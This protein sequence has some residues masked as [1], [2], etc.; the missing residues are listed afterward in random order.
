MTWPC[1]WAYHG[2]RVE[3][4]VLAPQWVSCTSAFTAA[5][6][7]QHPRQMS[8]MP[9]ELVIAGSGGCAEVSRP[10]LR[11]KQ[12]WAWLPILAVG[13]TIIERASL[14]SQI[15]YLSRLRAESERRRQRTSEANLQVCAMNERSLRNVGTELHNE[16]GQRLALALLKFGALEELVAAASAETPLRAV[17]HKEGLAA[18]RKALD[19]TLKHI[20]CVAGAFP[21]ADIEDLSLEQMFARA[22]TQHGRRTG[23]PVAF[24]SQGLP[25]KLSLPLK[26]S[27]YRFALEGLDST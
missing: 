20:R 13:S 18:I 16:A 22:A 17:D 15:G 23:F 7:K 26:A 14:P 24:E 8:D 19:E 3:A 10:R 2:T 5:C 27:L 21:P 11:I 4:V 1:L 25:E 9:F 6:D 12:L